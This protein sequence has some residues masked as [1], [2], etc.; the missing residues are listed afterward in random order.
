MKARVMLI[1]LGL[2]LF[3]GGC[4]KPPDAEIDRARRTFSKI[5][6]D[7]GDLNQGQWWEVQ[8]ARA[9]IDKEVESQGKKFALFR[10]YTRTKELLREFDEISEAVE[11]GTVF[12]TQGQGGSTEL[13]CQCTCFPKR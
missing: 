9:A 5:E 2:S 6:E 4:A 11:A 1:L 10:S 8:K 12:S 3:F 7:K 13:E